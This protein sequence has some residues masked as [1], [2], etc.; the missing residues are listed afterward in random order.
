MEV[1][2]ISKKRVYINIIQA[3]SFSIVYC[4]VKIF[5]FDSE[6]DSAL[7]GSIGGGFV[8]FLITIIFAKPSENKFS[9]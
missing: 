6:I 3:I 2:M 9:Q 8:L 4:L 5:F 7:I 1:Y